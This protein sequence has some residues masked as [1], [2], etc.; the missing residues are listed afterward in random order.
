MPDQ[1]LAD[2]ADDTD[3]PWTQ[4][5]HASDSTER[6]FAPSRNAPMPSDEEDAPWNLY[7]PTVAPNAPVADTNS[8]VWST[9]LEA[10]RRGLRESLTDRAH[11]VDQ[12][13]DRA[14]EAY[15]P[16]DHVSKLL[17]QPVSQSSPALAAL[18][19]STATPYT[20]CVR[21]SERP[22]HVQW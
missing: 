6:N 3:G 18:D 16:N 15:D 2:L 12:F 22:L 17:A 19:C 11:A 5:Q 13:R 7:A 21:S 20:D 4:F 14:A 8:G 9:A 1:T 10:G